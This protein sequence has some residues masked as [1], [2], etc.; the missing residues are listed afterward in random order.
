MVGELFSGKF[1]GKVAYCVV[2]G[3]RYSGD[4]PEPWIMVEWL[5]CGT[6]EEL[7]PDHMDG[8]SHIV[9][10]DGGYRA[11]T[12]GPLYRTH[13]EAMLTRWE[14]KDPETR[15]GEE[16]VRL[17]GGNPHHNSRLGADSPVSSSSP[18]SD[19]SAASSSTP[20]SG[21]SP[22][23]ALGGAFVTPESQPSPH[24]VE[25]PEE[26]KYGTPRYPPPGSE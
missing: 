17:R 14:G 15:Y 20:T 23:L 26:S 2:L 11:L 8:Y 4:D 1:K 18:S 21:S 9:V 13:L 6:I 16:L 5:L 25:Q 24:D 3:S 19:T 12:R 22:S 7:W 10:P